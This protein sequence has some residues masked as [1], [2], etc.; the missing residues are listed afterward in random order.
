MK[1]DEGNIVTI[2][3]ISQELK[4]KFCV[5]V[6]L[7]V[8]FFCFWKAFYI[9]IYFYFYL[10]F[11]LSLPIYNFVHFMVLVHATVKRL[12]KTLFILSPKKCSLSLSLSHFP[13][14]NLSCASIW[15]QFL[16]THLYIPFGSLSLEC[17]A[18]PVTINLYVHLSYK[19][20]SMRIKYFLDLSLSLSL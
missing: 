4:V 6:Y 18:A 14:C 8:C 3:N 19:F 5:I 12:R 9:V 16:A 2:I 13:I 15:L 17:W 1:M 11:Y 20:L 10:S 7:F